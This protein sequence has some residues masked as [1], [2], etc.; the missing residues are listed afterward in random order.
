MLYE[1]ITFNMGVVTANLPRIAIRAQGSEGK[2]YRLLDELLE[3]CKEG[4]LY[5]IERLKGRNNFV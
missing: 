3:D 2:F 4:L 5:R 1:V